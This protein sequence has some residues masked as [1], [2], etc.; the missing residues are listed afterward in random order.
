LFLSVIIHV[1]LIKS[2]IYKGKNKRS[3]ELV[4]ML[5]DQFISKSDK[6]QLSFQDVISSA[7]LVRSFFQNDNPANVSCVNRLSTSKCR[8][9]KHH[10]ACISHQKRMQ[11][12]CDLTCGFCVQDD[13]SC[14][15]SLYGCCHDGIT[16]ATGP[17]SNYGCPKEYCKDQMKSRFCK[18]LKKNGFC[19][20]KKRKVA[21]RCQKTCGMCRSCIDKD[22][23]KCNILLQHSLCE[24]KKYLAMNQCRRSCHKCGKRDPCNDFSCP[25]KHKCRAGKDGKPYCLCHQ[26]CTRGDHYT[27]HLCG[28]NGKTYQHLCELKQSFCTTGETITVKH[29]GK[30]KNEN[31]TKRNLE[32]AM[33][34]RCSLRKHDQPYCT[35]YLKFKPKACDKELRKMI[36]YCP[37]SCGFCINLLQL[38]SPYITCR[39]T[40]HGCCIDGFTP[41]TNSQGGGCPKQT[42]KDVTPSFCHRFLPA[43]GYENNIN[44][45]KYYCT[46]TCYYC[47]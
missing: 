12:Y 5:L 39:Y 19:E 27:G 14:L 8:Y 18:I 40:K 7:N 42:C 43:C 29:Y 22:P 45:M 47:I 9:L 10:M 6:G 24:K 41:A 33:L 1:V 21:Q 17:P 11:G 16:T 35:I 28:R 23:I 46:K 31:K 37:H 38:H 26:H 2:E 30:C 3:T 25:L 4:E 20:N 15:K 32:R 34:S 44:H 36:L 13:S